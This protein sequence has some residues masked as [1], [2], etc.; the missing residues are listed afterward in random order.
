MLARPR[1][2][3]RYAYCCRSASGTAFYLYVLVVRWRCCLEGEL[4]V[5]AEKRAARAPLPA[6]AAIFVQRESQS[7]SSSFLASSLPHRHK[8][9]HTRTLP[10]AASSLQ[11]TNQPTKLNYAPRRPRGCRRRG[12]RAA[13]AAPPTATPGTRSPA[14]FVWFCVRVFG[15]LCEGQW[16]KG[17]S[18]KR[19]RRFAVGGDGEE[20]ALTLHPPR[21]GVSG[22]A[23]G[24]SPSC[25]Q[26]TQCLPQHTP[27]TCIRW[28]MRFW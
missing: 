15:Y 9:I 8:D 28:R 19:R 21:T 5:E 17:G 7:S 3:P 27:Q 4:G 22:T 6:A 26:C 18:G 25:T 23:R 10:A 12:S 2:T 13:A 16:V 1:Q 14:P 24:T 11:L 20:R